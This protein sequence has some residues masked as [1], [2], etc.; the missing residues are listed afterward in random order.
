MIDI[1]ADLAAVYDT[2]PCGGAVVVSRGSA[3]F[4]GFHD[5]A[6]ANAFDLAS[7]TTHT[8][9]YRVGEMVGRGDVLTIDGARYRVSEVPQRLNRDEFVAELVRLP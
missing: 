1:A 2:G 7:T 9:R 6:S 4:A 8:L 3:R 5:P